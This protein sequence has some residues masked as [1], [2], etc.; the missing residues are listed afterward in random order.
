KPL[1]KPRYLD[2]L[3]LETPSMA[4]EAARREMHRMG[5]RLEDMLQEIFHATTLG[6]R[7]TLLRVRDMDNEVDA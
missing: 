7:D 1:L 3:L 2:N 4:L 5:T 6:D